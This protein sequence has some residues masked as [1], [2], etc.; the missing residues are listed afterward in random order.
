MIVF[1]QVCR[2]SNGF[3]FRAFAAQAQELVTRKKPQTFYESLGVLP[4]ATQREIKNAYYELA[5]K[6]HPDTNNDT[7]FE[8]IFREI[9]EAYQVLGNVESRKVYDQEVGSYFVLRGSAK[10]E[11]MRPVWRLLDDRIVNIDARNIKQ[12]ESFV[13]HVSSLSSI[14]GVPVRI[15]NICRNSHLR[16]IPANEMRAVLLLR[17]ICNGT[18]SGSTGSS[19]V[20]LLPSDIQCGRYYIDA[21]QFGN[22]SDLIPYAMP[23]LMFAPTPRIGRNNVLFLNGP[24]YA[25]NGMHIDHIS[26]VYQRVMSQFGISFDV[27]VKKRG[28]L[29]HGRGSVVV[30]SNPIQYLNNVEM[31]DPG[32]VTKITGRA[33]VAGGK[34]VKIAQRMA[35]QAQMLLKE[36]FNDISITIDSVHESASR[37]EGMGQGILI[38]AETSTSCVFSGSGLWKKGV[39]TETVV[40]VAIQ[41]LMSNVNSGG[42]VDS[43]MQDQVIKPMALAR[44]TSV[45]RTGPLTLK[46]KAA[47]RAIKHLTKVRFK[48]IKE[49]SSL[50]TNLIKCKG[51]GYTNLYLD[52]SDNKS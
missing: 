15:T 52:N 35:K 51:L 24:T 43:W 45:V 50:D 17:Q 26:K 37:S 12:S 4:T 10:K 29:P 9:T 39:E 27:E 20:T 25:Y 31:V 5:M 36:M 3:F 49:K 18:L 19:T 22:V 32:V 28:S 42:C 48:V 33:F 44:G 7:Q 46:T 1:G 14:L 16:G 38:V 6:Y 40:N 34:P 21:Y 2:R 47:L 8:H 30:R 11:T 23:P 13:C 41:E